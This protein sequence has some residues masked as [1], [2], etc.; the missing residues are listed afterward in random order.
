MTYTWKIVYIVRSELRK[1]GS[2]YAVAL[3]EAATNPEA[4]FAFR[5]QYAGQF[6]TIEKIEKI[7]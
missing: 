1:G 4:S 5:Q 3:V 6:H 2:L 7:G